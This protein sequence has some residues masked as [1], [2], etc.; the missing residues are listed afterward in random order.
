MSLA[1]KTDPIRFH[2]SLNVSDLKRAITFYRV[3]FGCAPA[4]ERNDYAK[5]ELEDPPVVLSLEPSPPGTGGP[6]NHLGF[7]LADSATLVAMQ[8]RLAKEGI[9]TQREEGVECCYAKQTKFWVHDPDRTLW[10]V[11]TFEGDIDHRGAGQ[12]QEKI[13]PP[14]SPHAPVQQVAWE[15][16]LGQ[17]VPP[18]AD[19]A[20]ASVDEVRLRGSL[21][22]PLAVSDA[23][24]LFA[25]AR[26]ILK[27]GGRL[28]VHTLVAERP[29]AGPPQLPGAAAYVQHAPLEGETVALIEEA[30]FVG[31]RLVKYDAS[32]C[33]VRDG[34]GL[35]EQQ[36]EG[37]QPTSSG[38]TVQ[39]LYKGPFAQVTDDSGLV[40]P[41]GQRV[42]VDARVADRLCQGEM[43]TAF[44]VIDSQ[45]D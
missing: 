32:P 14:A 21:N 26:R 38:P 25:E 12:A 43:A 18:R 24:R 40:Y 45:A 37:F 16:R 28:F 19:F 41:R 10:E 20:D 35:R 4:K 23:R 27:P 33:F 22:V 17:P 31:G 5:F 29:L 6:L 2:L 8:M 39:V 36:L 7:R 11:Y 30:G 13:L 44:L 34:I 42:S 1:L 15:H 3:L 9:E